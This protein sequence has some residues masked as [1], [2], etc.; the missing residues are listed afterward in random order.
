M[1]TFKIL[2]DKEAELELINDDY[3]PVIPCELQWR[4]WAGNSQG[5]TGDALKEFIDGNLFP[6]LQNLDVSTGNKRAILIRDIF[7]GTNNNMKKGQLSAR[8]LIN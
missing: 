2:D 8:L 4:I 5:I 6:G 3:V 7:A 1:I